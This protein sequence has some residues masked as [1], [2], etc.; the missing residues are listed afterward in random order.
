MIFDKKVRKR[1]KRRSQKN[2]DDMLWQE[3]TQTEGESGQSE[4]RERPHMPSDL[5]AHKS[6]RRRRRKRRRI[7]SL[8]LVVLL[9]LVGVI[10]YFALQR[11]SFGSYQVVTVSES[12]TASDAHFALLDSR[13][14]K[15]SVDGVS[16]LDKKMESVWDSTY[17]MQNPMIDVCAQ[18]AVIYNQS[19]TNMVVIDES[20]VL[21]EVTT[22][23]PIVKAK[24]AKQGVVAA[25]LDDG[26]ST[27][28]NFYQSDGTLIAENQTRVDDPGYPLDIAVSEDG[29]LIMVS[30]QFV[31]SE[32]TTSYVAFYNFGETGQS[33]IDNLVSGFTYDSTVVPQVKLLEDSLFVAYRDNGISLYS[34]QQ[35][36]KEIASIAIEEE[37]VST[38][39]GDGVVG[40]VY[41]NTSGDEQYTMKVYDYKG[42][43]KFERSFSISFTS[44]QVSGGYIIL[45][46]DTQVSVFNLSGVEKYN[47]NVDEGT[48]KSLLKT[49]FNRYFLAT[50][51]GIQSIKFK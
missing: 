14:L 27:W 42:E 41:K 21:G 3:D 16:L 40:M 17:T 5:E 10:A 12:Q 23:L 26:D 15:Y 24:V 34:G 45:N 51:T 31:E 28:I 20:G 36:P 11:M 39:S 37:I 35:V 33:Q 46:N 19:G 9:V 8:I 25:I 6:K 13:V 43:E 49:G 32:S 4:D 50:D 38:F 44:I 18:T 29:L 47:G 48:I 30:Y 2:L 7:R 22:T 1:R